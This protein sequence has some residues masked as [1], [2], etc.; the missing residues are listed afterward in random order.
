[1]GHPGKHGHKGANGG[2]GY[3]GPKGHPGLPGY[4]GEAVIKCSTILHTYY[5]FFTS[6]LFAHSTP[7]LTTPHTHILSTPT[8]FHT[9]H[10]LYPNTPSISTR[11]PHLPILSSTPPPLHPTHPTNIHTP[12]AFHPYIL[13]P[14]T[15]HHNTPFTISQLYHNTT[16]YLIPY[17]P[18]TNTHTQHTQYHGSLLHPVHHYT[19]G[20]LNTSNQYL[21]FYREMLAVLEP[22]VL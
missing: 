1:M 13:H 18:H 6:S 7:I 4:P 21:H 16:P 5:T 12:H 15:L 19:C 22:R 14:H 3:E 2:E 10:T 8:H 17:T 11:T 20:L 9:Q